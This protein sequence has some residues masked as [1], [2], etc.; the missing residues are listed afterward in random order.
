ML[1]GEFQD[2]DACGIELPYLEA[3]MSM[4]ILLPNKRMGITALND[5]INHMNLHGL[6]ERMRETKVSVAL[7][8]FHAEKQY[9]LKKALIDVTIASQYFLLLKF[10]LLP[11]L[12]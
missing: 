12:F 9:S 2:L 8:K 10:D 1:Y 3:N 11:F 4:L 7:P 6:T 5:K